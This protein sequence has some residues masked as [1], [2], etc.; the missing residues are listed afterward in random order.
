MDAK[1]LPKRAWNKVSVGTRRE[2]E[3][4]YWQIKTENGWEFEQ[5]AVM[6]EYLGRQLCKHEQVHHVNGDRGDNRIENLELWSVSQPAGQRV[7]DK[8]NWALE[9]LRTYAPERLK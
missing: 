9:W 3:R 4:G 2:V 6:Y 5:R 7:S 1:K 8:T